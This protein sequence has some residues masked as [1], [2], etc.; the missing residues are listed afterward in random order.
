MAHDHPESEP[1]YGSFGNASQPIQGAGC[2]NDDRCAREA[3]DL[4]N[5]I[6]GLSPDGA[7]RVENYEQAQISIAKS[8]RRLTDIAEGL[9]GLGESLRGPAG[10]KRVAA[11]GLAIKIAMDELDG[12][13]PPEEPAPSVELAATI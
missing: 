1:G 11:Y 4:G 10:A 8:L 3:V 12:D 13:V 2:G 9:L 7:D 6:G 5:L